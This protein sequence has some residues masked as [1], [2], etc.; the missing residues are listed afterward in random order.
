MRAAANIA[1]AAAK[2]CPVWSAAAAVLVDVARVL[3]AGLEPLE[4]EVDREVD[5]AGGR[6][7][8][9]T[10]GNNSLRHS[11]GT[12]E[13]KM[14]CSASGQALTQ[15]MRARPDRKVA[16]VQFSSW[17]PVSSPWQKLEIGGHLW[18]QGPLGFWARTAKPED[19][20]TSA[21]NRMFAELI[22]GLPKN[23][24][25]VSETDD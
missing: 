15:V 2:D 19:R 20:Q 18:T 4:E 7:V 13:A 21:E 6:D 17:R 11:V 3:V 1:A 10:S 22:G 9:G 14:L 5:E 25:N 16:Q 24:S 12:R 23:C 8:V